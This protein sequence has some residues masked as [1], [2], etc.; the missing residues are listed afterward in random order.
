E[1]I[2]FGASRS[3]YRHIA[4]L[5]IDATC[6]SESAEIV[7]VS[8]AP[9]YAVEDPQKINLV[10]SRLGKK[11][12]LGFGHGC[13]IVAQCCGAAVERLPFGDHGLN[14]PV[15]YVGGGR[16]EITVQNHNYV[17]IPDGSAE[18]LF[19]NVHDGTCEGFVCKEAKAAGANFL[20][21]EAWFQAMLDALK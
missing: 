10:K 15:R 4:S 3:F 9:Y 6:D 11:P 16:N 1:V 2:D 8:D 7:I 17:V 21:N 19:E 20:P 18:R 5:G 14:I 12:V 13:A